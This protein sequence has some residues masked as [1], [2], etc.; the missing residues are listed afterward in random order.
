MSATLVTYIKA[1]SNKHFDDTVALRRHMHMHPELSYEE[2]ETGK[3]I[4]AK[5]TE[6]GIAHTHG[7]AEN[8]VI[9]IIEGKNPSQKVVA[10]R[11]DF[12]ALPIF[13][14]NDV[15][16]KSTNPGVMHAC[17]H[18]AHTS[19]LLTVARILDATKNDWCGT[20]KL[21]FQP[22]EEKLPGGAKRMIEE[23]ALENP[24]PSHIIG[25]HVLPTLE[26]GKVGF[27]PG[28]YMAS[29]DEIYITVRGKGG[30]GAMPNRG[31]DPVLISAH[32]IVAMQQI[33]SRHCDPIMPS[34]LTF[35][36]VIAD[37]ATNIIPDVVHMEATFRTLDETWRS[38]A[39]R[40][41]V[42]MAEGL[43]ESMGGACEFRIERG[44]PSLFNDE[45]LTMRTRAAAVEYLGKDNVIDLP[46]RMTA[47]DFA[48]Y[49]QKMPACFYRLGTGNVARGITSQLHTSTFD[50]DEESLRLSPGLMAWLAI[51]ELSV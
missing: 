26:T 32:L 30:H 37:G 22:A 45:I 34:V 36:R 17:G 28:I 20:V 23:G 8:G 40:I 11:A 42:R 47:E 46:I 29:A 1:L 9:A 25:Q 18:D 48:Y 35:G 43:A 24:S 12:D 21:L 39:H 10:L 6:Y 15:P 14:T 50:V 31:I 41:M 13:E 33:V 3:F 49:S 2:T 7:I 4:A 5:L 19:S 51:Q 27:K 16:Y 38:E 44:Y